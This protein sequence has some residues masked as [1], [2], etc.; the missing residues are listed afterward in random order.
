MWKK[1]TKLFHIIVSQRK[2][3]NRIHTIKDAS[4]MINSEPERIENIFVDHF[5]DL[6]QSYPTQNIDE[7]VEVFKDRITQPIKDTLELEARW[8]IS[9][10]NANWL[11]YPILEIWAYF[12]FFSNMSLKYQNYEYADFFEEDE[13]AD[14]SSKDAQLSMKIK[15]TYKNCSTQ[16]I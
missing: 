9:E 10:R 11:W 16:M 6:F 15:I 12:S 3:R 14:F 13:Y 7:A 2:K 4:G 1:N 8:A 5:K